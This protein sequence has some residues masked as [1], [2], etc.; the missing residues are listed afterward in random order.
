[1]K[2]V[3]REFG[4]VRRPTGIGTPELTEEREPLVDVVTGDKV[5]QVIAEVPGVE[6]EDIN[7][8]TTEDRLT[9]SVDTEKRKYHKEVELP[10]PV[11]PKSAKASYKNGVLEVTLE[12]VREKA[13]PGKKISIE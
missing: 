8:Y 9:I 6:K 13:P 4:N 1:G 12:R 2:P 3:I 5:V 10:V 7:L 11:E